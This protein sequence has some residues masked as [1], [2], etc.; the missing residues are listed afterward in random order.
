MTGDRRATGL[1]FDEAPT[2]KL[3]QARWTR[4]EF[5]RAR[6]RS[7]QPRRSRSCSSR[8]GSPARARPPACDHNATPRR[9]P[10]WRH[11]PPSRH[12]C[13]RPKELFVWLGQPSA[14][15]RSASSR[16]ETGI[17]VTYDKA[18]RPTQMAS[19]RRRQGGG[20]DISYPAS[21][22]MPSFIAD[23]LVTS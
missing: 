6:P 11:P 2:Q 12:P 20:Y 10:Q 17:K 15:T 21:T 5:L 7:A 22:W 16:T 8:A 3:A 1:T 13:P 14:R 18:P 23:G 9:P 19:S 4:R